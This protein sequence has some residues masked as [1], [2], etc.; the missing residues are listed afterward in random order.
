MK[1]APSSVKSKLAPG[2]IRISVALALTGVLILIGSGQA[3]GNV[4]A[5]QA[6]QYA[7]QNRCYSATYWTN[8]SE[9]AGAFVDISIVHFKCTLLCASCTACT[10]DELGLIDNEIWLTDK[11]SPD[12]QTTAPTTC[13]IETGYMM[14]YGSPNEIFFWY[15]KRPGSAPAWELINQVGPAPS[16]A[17]TKS[18]VSTAATVIVSP[19]PTPVSTLPIEPTVPVN[20]YKQ[21]VHFMIV[22]DLR[23]NDPSFM[24]RIYVDGMS[25]PFGGTSS[26]NAMVAKYI[27]M[28]QELHGVKGATADRATFTRNL[29]TIQPLNAQNPSSFAYTSQGKAKN[30]WS[31]TPPMGNWDIEPATSPDGGEFSTSCC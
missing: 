22:K 15:D 13:W 1:A 26:S 20:F 17:H 11:D 18:I 16:L 9:Y 5:Q 10:A 7:C 24:I 29:F 19:N 2:S 3:L 23:S 14:H 21:N 28:G 12:C 8:G 25:A 4:G 31:D 6:T 27:Y 30:A